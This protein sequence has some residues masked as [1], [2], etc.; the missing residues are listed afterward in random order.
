MVMG[1]EKSV[2]FLDLHPEFDAY[3]IYSDENGNFKT[4]MTENLKGLVFEE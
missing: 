3:L 2:E 4:W 1:K